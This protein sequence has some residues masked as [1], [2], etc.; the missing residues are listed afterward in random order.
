M[1]RQSEDIEV[2]SDTLIKATR[3]VGVMLGVP[4]EGRP[5]PIEWAMAYAGLRPPINFNFRTAIVYGKE[6]ADARNGIA[7]AAIRE[8]CEFV[9][10]LGDDVQPPPH[11]IGNLIYYMRQNPKIGVIGGIYCSK[12]DKPNPLVF[13]GNGKGSYWNWKT[14]EIFQVTGI[15]MDCTLIRIQVFEDLGDGPW[16]ETIR[17]DQ[18]LDNVASA[19]SWTEDLKF[20]KRVT[21][22]TDWEIWADGGSVCKHWE[23]L[24]GKNWKFFSLPTD[25]Y[26]VVAAEK[27]AEE[28]QRTKVLLDIGCGTIHHRFD[29]PDYKVVRLDIREECNPDYRCDVRRLPFGP[30]MADTVFS[31]HVL[32]HVNRAEVFD[33]LKEWTRVLKSGGDLQLIVPNLEYAAKKIIEDDL[34]Y[35]SMN[36]LYGEQTYDHNYHQCG[37]TEK[38][39]T[40]LMKQCGLE[41]VEIYNGAKEEPINYQLSVIGRKPDPDAE[42]ELPDS[43]VKM[44]VAEDQDIK[45]GNVVQVN[46][47]GEVEKFDL[48]EYL[49]MTKKLEED[50]GKN[51]I[52]PPEQ[53]VQ[54]S[55]VESGQEPMDLPWFAASQGWWDSGE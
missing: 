32:E 54:K 43:V 47:H 13:R 12:S 29:D 14:G 39:L 21:D 37:F 53:D 3:E 55:V 2:R 52:A 35:D 42:E 6:V 28:A 50:N 22:E 31:S 25:S 34:N 24:G 8:N 15:G 33:T 11:A 38:S 7:Q 4:T 40:S 51:T 5:I 45:A 27:D 36:V 23:Y 48:D 1:E 19:E 17:K 20:C 26:P 9:F 41:I 44:K 16:F 46:S 49:K 30:E 18:Y 10:F